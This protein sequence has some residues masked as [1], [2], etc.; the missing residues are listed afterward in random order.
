MAEKRFAIRR[1]SVKSDILIPGSRDAAS[2][3]ESAAEYEQDA[4]NAYGSING[5]IYANEDVAA[6]SDS[7]F[8][9]TI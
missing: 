6:Q 3:F 5:N 1:W 7:C 8:I 4:K 2:L 9:H